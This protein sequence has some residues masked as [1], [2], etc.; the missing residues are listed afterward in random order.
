MHFEANYVEWIL[1][2][3]YA[4]NQKFCVFMS[5]STS[6]RLKAH[7][8]GTS[9][10]GFGIFHA[11]GMD[12]EVPGTVSGDFAEIDVKPSQGR[13]L[14]S[15]GRLVSL[16]RPSP[17]RIPDSAACPFQDG[18]GGCPLGLL[19]E[20]AQLAFKSRMLKDSLRKAGFRN[21]PVFPISP[22]PA[23]TTRFK[24]IRFFAQGGS[25]VVQGFYRQGSHAVGAVGDCPRECAWFG[26][27]AE[28][29]AGLASS[30]GV[31]AY[32][33]TSHAGVLRALMMR[34]CGKGQS[35][36]VL[37]H[38]GELQPSFVKAL[39]ALMQ[40][41]GV[42]SSWTLQNDSFGN[43]IMDG[44]LRHLAGAA[45]V[46]VRLN[47]FDYRAGP[48]TFLQVNYPVAQ[49]LYKAALAWCGSDPEGT[50]L[51]LCCGAGAMT[52]PLA[53][54]FKKAV[55]V[56]IVEEAVEAARENARSNSIGNAVFI[57]G[58]LA[59]E[60]PNLIDDRVS[61]AIAD[62][63][64]RGLG[65]RACRDLGGLRHGA[66]LALIFCGLRALERDLPVVAEGGFAVRSVQ[67]FDM[68]PGTMSLEV[69]VLLEKDR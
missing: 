60:L 33:E 1:H 61:A 44:A 16:I 3:N 5:F 22:S 9:I 10:R 14:R 36:A 35:L 34:E 24:G 68:F 28:K 64:R 38:A 26:G 27:L 40:E 57:A 50:A 39:A 15:F 54:A 25:K 51:D 29:I 42:A 20:S 2:F 7:A 19:K 23:G 52:L 6:A 31:L 30:M 62:P 41:E 47:G 13:R 46:S 45:S 48:G 69:L 21:A 66:R 32:D 58:D 63:S 53:C 65:E 8:S 59:E 4:G 43:S 12:V 56:E 49:H 67:G 18:C 55:G 17:D 11:C 37:C